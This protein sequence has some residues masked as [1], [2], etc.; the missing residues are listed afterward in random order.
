MSS[1]SSYLLVLGEEF[2]LREDLAWTFFHTA[3]FSQNFYLS[4]QYYSLEQLFLFY[5]MV[6]SGQE[7]AED[8]SAT[9][10]ISNDEQTVGITFSGP[11]LAIDR[12]GYF[13]LYKYF[14]KLFY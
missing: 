1:S 4:V 10:S 3:K 8:Y 7:V 9:I 13:F 5:V 12:F 14:S 11:V 6:D 2:D